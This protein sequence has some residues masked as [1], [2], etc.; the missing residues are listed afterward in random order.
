MPIDR[1]FIIDRIED[2][3]CILIDRDE[4][5]LRIPLD[6]CPDELSEGDAVK[7]SCENGEMR[8]TGSCRE[9]T[10]LRRN[11]IDDKLARLRKKK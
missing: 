11:R 8:I 10:V 3:F 5:L 1:I 9:Q 2:G 4:N 7:V 6:S